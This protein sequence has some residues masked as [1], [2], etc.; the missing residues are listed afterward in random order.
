MDN[1]VQALGRR[2]FL[3]VI[4]DSM[5]WYQLPSI[6]SVANIHVVGIAVALY[7]STS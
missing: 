4:R 5:Y 6:C 7:A 1:M 3:L 2:S